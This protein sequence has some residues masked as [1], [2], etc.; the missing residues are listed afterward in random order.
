MCIPKLRLL[1][2]LVVGERSNFKKILRTRKIMVMH[3]NKRGECCLR[4]LVDRQRKR[5]DNAVDVVVRLHGP[6]D[7]APKLRHLRVLAHVQLDDDPR[8]PIQQNVGEEFRQHDGMVTILMFYCRRA[9]PK[10]HYNIIEDYGGRGHRTRLRKRSRG[11][12]SVSRGAPCPR[13]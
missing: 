7:Q 11:S 12:T 1:P 9:S 6:T 2:L 3:S 10:H 5:Y 4:T 8:T 13:I